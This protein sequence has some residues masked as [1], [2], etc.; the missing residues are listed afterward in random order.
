MLNSNAVS[1]LPNGTAIL[2]DFPDKKSSMAL[3]SCY[4][5]NIFPS[6]RVAG[7]HTNWGS[8]LE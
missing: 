4:Y 6:L 1:S 2:D 8:G 3:R 7:T 5:R